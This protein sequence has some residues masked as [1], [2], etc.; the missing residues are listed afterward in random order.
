MA[1]IVEETPPGSRETCRRAEHVTRGDLA[2]ELVLPR[3]ER[4]GLDAAL[5]HVDA[6]DSRLRSVVEYRFFGGLTEQEIARVHGVTVRTVQRDWVKAR[7]RL[8]QEIYPQAR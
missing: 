6:L 4:L 1:D 3:K 2:A 5:T 7:A 8:Y